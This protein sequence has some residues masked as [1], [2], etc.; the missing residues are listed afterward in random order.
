[1]NGQANDGRRDKRTPSLRPVFFSGTTFIGLFPTTSLP[2]LWFR[3]ILSMGA[4][5]FGQQR[6]TELSEARIGVNGSR[7]IK[8][9]PEDEQ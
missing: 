4:H 6:I 1:M 5:T 2:D 3:L 7:E 9:T 8:V